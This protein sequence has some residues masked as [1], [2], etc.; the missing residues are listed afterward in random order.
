M[1]LFVAKA[2]EF[3]NTWLSQQDDE[4]PEEKRLKFSKQW[5]K[6]WMKE[7]GVSL[8]KPNKRFAISRAERKI[9]II[10]FLKNVWRVRYWFRSKFGREIPIIN[11]DQMPLHRNESADQNTCPSRERL[12]S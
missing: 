3:Y 11:G 6:G 2:N 12:L 5:I 8:R 4:G 10:E 9:R 7:Y 1:K